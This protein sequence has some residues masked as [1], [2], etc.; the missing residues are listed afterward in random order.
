MGVLITAQVKTALWSAW[1]TGAHAH[2][3][4][5]SAARRAA[6]QIGPHRKGPPAKQET[7]SYPQEMDGLDGSA[8][9]AGETSDAGWKFTVSEE[10][11]VTLRKR[12]KK[13]PFKISPFSS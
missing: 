12:A 9:P 5:R 3:H 10:F 11:R 4:T 2:T 13:K 1:Q 6:Y 8:D 7:R